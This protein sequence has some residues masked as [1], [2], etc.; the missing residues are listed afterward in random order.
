MTP[1]W[2]R[3]EDDL[4]FEIKLLLRPLSSMTEDEKKEYNQRKQRKVCY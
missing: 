4:S 3:A 1:L 2:P